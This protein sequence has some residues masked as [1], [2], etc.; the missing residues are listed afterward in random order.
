MLSAMEI[1]PGVSMPRIGLGTFRCRGEQAGHAVAAA[2]QAGFRHIDT[3]SIYKNYDA[4]LQGIKTSGVPRQ[5]VFITSK[6]SPYEQG[7]EAATASVDACLTALGALH[8][9]W[10]PRTCLSGCMPAF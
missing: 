7:F 8:C 5:D 4:V 3:A 2:L 9:L 10:L 6:V 1:A